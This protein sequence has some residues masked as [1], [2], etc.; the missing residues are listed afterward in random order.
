MVFKKL[1]KKIVFFFQSYL[2]D[3]KESL[4]NFKDLEEC[5]KKLEGHQRIVNNQLRLTDGERV[6]KFLA[7][8]SEEFLQRMAQ[9]SNRSVKNH[10]E[11]QTIPSEERSEK[12]RL[13]STC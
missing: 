3:P 11:F 12:E 1:E 4:N 13:E 2:E 5:S 8:I 10:R 6:L 7:E 9:K